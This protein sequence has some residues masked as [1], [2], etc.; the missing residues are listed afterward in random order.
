M[1]SHGS[2]QEGK[3]ASRTWGKFPFLSTTCSP[4]EILRPHSRQTRFNAHAHSDRCMSLSRPA[5]LSFACFGCLPS[6]LSPSIPYAICPCYSAFDADNGTAPVVAIVA[7]SLGGAFLV[8]GLILV[9]LFKT[10]RIKIVKRGQSSS[11]S[12]DP[13]GSASY[14][15]VRQY[16]TIAQD[17]GAAQY[18]TAPQN[19]GAAQ[20]PTVPRYPEPT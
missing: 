3:V 15:V 13:S 17:S 11:P 7:G 1:Y 6:C 12:A 4:A 19:S 14:P 10:G 18:P 2:R 8:V 20:Y 9:A 5:Y 16:P